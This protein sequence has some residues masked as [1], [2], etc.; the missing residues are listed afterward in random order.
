MTSPLSSAGPVTVRLALSGVHCG[1]CV[2]FIEEV[3]MDQTGVAA[4]MV[5]LEA[6]AARVTFDPSGVSVDA[7][8]AA[9]TGAG[10]GASLVDD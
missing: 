5:D 10:Y 3:L 4:A 6:G 9:V 1:S 2:A 8:C 7:L